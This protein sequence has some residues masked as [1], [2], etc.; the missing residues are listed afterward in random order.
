M[1]FPPLPRP[2]LVRGILDSPSSMRRPNGPAG[3]GVYLS[4]D[5]EEARQ[6]GDV[7]L[8]VLAYTGRVKRMQIQ[9]KQQHRGNDEQVDSYYYFRARLFL[10]KYLIK[11][12]YNFT[13]VLFSE[14][15]F[16]Q[17]RCRHLPQER[18]ERKSAGEETE[19][20]CVFINGYLS[21]NIISGRLQG[22]VQA[23]P[24]RAV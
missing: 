1:L 14:R 12:R 17:Q 9:Q 13:I 21:F 3:P 18:E 24:F 10:K 20:P 2:G 4:R 15:T 22:L 16:G 6:F 19:N 5:P 8:K 7:V 23:G 11:T